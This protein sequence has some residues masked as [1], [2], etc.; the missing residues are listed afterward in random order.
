MFYLVPTIIAALGLSSVVPCR[1]P[2][3]SP[4]TSNLS[5]EA[6]TLSTDNS[7][8]SDYPVRSKTSGSSHRDLSL[9]RLGYSASYIRY[10]RYFK[11]ANAESTLALDFGVTADEF[12]LLR[13]QV[14]AL[15]RGGV[16]KYHP[17]TSIETYGSQIAE[18]VDQFLLKNAPSAT[19]LLK[20]WICAEAVLAFSASYVSYYVAPGDA[21]EVWRVNAP[22]NVLSLV[23]P[24]CQC[25][26]F[27]ML[28]RDLANA[29]GAK[30]GLRC[31]YVGGWLRRT[32]KPA[33]RTSNHAWNLFIFD[34]VGPIPADATCASRALAGETY[35]GRQDSRDSLFFCLPI[36]RA[37]WEMFLAHYWGDQ[38]IRSSAN[39]YGIDY[40]L[41]KTGVKDSLTDLTFAQWNA[42]ETSSY[43]SLRKALTTRTSH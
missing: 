13:K 8:Y 23:R 38:Y 24:K 39:I 31:E 41:S 43:L 1:H 19:N 42:G 32:G 11:G 40:K 9:E 28:T 27:S 34:G 26:G 7:V 35:F 2:S 5:K 15:I 30:F 10:S 25:S 22:V 16:I 37:E 3:N 14:W 29:A 17:N 36:S 12:G 33:D 6:L 18:C 4:N 21:R 20:Q